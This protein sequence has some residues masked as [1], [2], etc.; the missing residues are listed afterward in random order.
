MAH[1]GSR[2]RISGIETRENRVDATVLKWVERV[3]HE[4]Q[5]IEA[6]ILNH[7]YLQALE[8]GRIERGQLRIFAGQ[9]SHIIG[10]DLRSVAQMVARASSE[11]SQAFFLELLEGERAALKA[12]ELFNAGV[13][14]AP[15]TPVSDDPLPGAFA[16]CAFVAWLSLYAS[17]AEF[18][19]ALLINLP[20]WGTN[21]GRMADA[22]RSRYGFSEA[23]VAFFT[24]FATAPPGFEERAAGVVAE[25][26]AH[27]VTPGSVR[28][29]ASLLQ[30]YELLFWDTMAQ[31]SMLTT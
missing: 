25:G 20:V 15:G 21:C 2:P 31:A 26:L 16:Y 12:L 28:Q 24:M 9:Q 23:E 13:A 4:L 19:G 7:R 17:E 8:A 18:A 6:K 10:S 11:R 22:L 30:G 3:R 5:P 1:R 14:A 29:A 27:G